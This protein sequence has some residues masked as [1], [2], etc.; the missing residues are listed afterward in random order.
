MSPI[1][2]TKL[3]PSVGSLQWDILMM[4]ARE[5]E[6]LGEKLFRG[7][8]YASPGESAISDEKIAYVFLVY[9]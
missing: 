2:P 5:A 7:I 1:Y 8:D 4:N 6:V 3:S 9:H